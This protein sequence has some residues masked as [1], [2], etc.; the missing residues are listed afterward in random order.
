MSVETAIQDVRFKQQ[1]FNLK[2]RLAALGAR[3]A[4]R[5]EAG[6]CL[7]GHDIDENTTPPEAGL[8]WVIGK[9]RRDV[10]AKN[11]FIGSERVL[12]QINNKKLYTR[13]RAGMFTKGP[14]AREG[15]IV[16]TVD[17]GKGLR[18]LSFVLHSSRSR[19]EHCGVSTSNPLP[20]TSRN[21][22]VVTT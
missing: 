7:Y 4:L 15:T 18:R 1:I 9:G 12:S 13:L 16:E 3:D 17:G 2:V 22:D 6:L 21:G 10:N 5:L 11:P 19:R 8:T 20:L 14:P